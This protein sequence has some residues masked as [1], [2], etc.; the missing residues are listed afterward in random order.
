MNSLKFSIDEE[1]KIIIFNW[2]S[3]GDKNQYKYN[4]CLKKYKDDN[5]KIIAKNLTRNDFKF[6]TTQNNI[7]YE[8]CIQVVEDAQR[9]DMGKVIVVKKQFA[10]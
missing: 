7:N 3:I 2:K 1:N 9:L 6:Y 8:F 10:E 5:F 4:I